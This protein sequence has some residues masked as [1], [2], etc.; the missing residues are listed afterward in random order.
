[1]APTSVVF[2]TSN[3]T[4]N[5]QIININGNLITNLTPTS[6]DQDGRIYRWLAASDCSEN[7]RAARALHHPQTGAW[8]IDGNEF[9]SWKQTPNS[10]MW[11]QGNRELRSR[12]SRTLLIAFGAAGCGKTILCSSAIDNVERVCAGKPAFAF[13][14]FFFDGRDSQIDLTLHDKMIRSLI[15]QLSKQAAG[16]P[17]PLVQLYDH[18]NHA[19]STAALQQTLAQIIEGFEHTYIIL[20]ALDECAD[21]TELLAWLGALLENKTGKTHV[22]FSSRPELDL[23]GA[24]SAPGL[25]R[26]RLS[27]Q[28]SNADIEKFLDQIITDTTKW[29]PPIRAR[30]KEVL[31]ARGEGMFRWVALQVADLTAC[32]SRRALENQLRDMPRDLAGS[33]ES[34]LVRALDANADHLK[35]FL[36]WLAF[37]RRPLAVDELAEAITVDFAAPGA[38]AY[39][40]DLRYFS[41][42]DMVEMCA[43]FITLYN[44]TAKLAHISVKEYLISDRI[45]HGPA[46]YFATSAALAQAVCAQTCVAYI[47]QMETAP[48][49]EVSRETFTLASYTSNYWMG[50]MPALDG[51][52]DGGVTWQLVRKLLALDKAGEPANW[53][54]IKGFSS[55]LQA[56]SFDGHSG[57]VQLL[58]EQGVDPNAHAQ[59]GGLGSALQTAAFQGHE[60]VV[61][62]LLAHGADANAAGGVWGSALIA[63]SVE[64]HTAI[65]RQLLAA[66]A[67]VNAA[68]GAWGAALQ[69]ASLSGYTDVVRL[70]IAHGADVNAGGG[71]FGGALQA[72]AYAGQEEVVR[73][74]LAHGAD[75]HAR[76][77][78]HDTALQAASYAHRDAIVKLL[79]DH[80]AV[81]EEVG[82]DKGGDM[83]Y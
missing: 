32:C 81:A 72:A 22:L 83:E 15:S 10:A 61:R 8:F 19:P 46:A 75:V 24:D 74:L 39:D 60:T 56:A 43:G 6:Q 77:G 13:A 53:V 18:G 16:L 11:L 26:V 76:G 47:L 20:D 70:L 73:I 21:R 67:N 68:G 5:A 52:D 66:G 9:G 31:I 2:H 45:A 40:T 62:L 29:D 51:G 4:G 63:A 71:D 37:A 65:A 59:E 58:L 54:R 25:V 57:V 14:Y 42:E 36:I 23:K 7:Y 28:T 69:A 41:A 79:V 80:G 30:V 3:T 44:G 12:P 34:R 1:M 33:Y 55:A 50:H 49:A 17:A 27:A 78:M 35:Q 64:G 48:L 82:A 38:P